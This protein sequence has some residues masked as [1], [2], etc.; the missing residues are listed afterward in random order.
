MMND[1]RTIVFLLD[2][3]NTLLDNDRFGT[4]LDAR[5]ERDFGAA[6]RQRYRDIYTRLRDEVGYSD[7]L[8]ALQTFRS[9]LDSESALLGM[10]SFILD[11]PFAQL[12]YPDA[13]VAIEHLASFG[14]TVIL[15][16][17]DIVLQPRKIQRSGLSE[18][19]QG[20]VLITVHKQHMLDSVERLYPADHYVIVDDKPQLLCAMKQLL[21][22]R[23]TGVFVRQGHY[24]REAPVE[25][26]V[27]PADLVI[28]HIGELAGFDRSRFKRHGFGPSTCATAI[29]QEMS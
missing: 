15:S 7:Y 22:D 13:V 28:D 6:Q 8:G 9:G 21:G 3:D 12:V 24:A 2:V 27:P 26:I 17:G 20:R 14:T 16:D 19:L 29:H 11:Y 25:S 18:L 1:E 10:S 23:M 4:D 5:L